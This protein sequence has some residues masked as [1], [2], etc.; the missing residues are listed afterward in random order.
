MRGSSAL[1]RIR[2]GR[3][4]EVAIGGVWKRRIWALLAIGVAVSVIGA[5]VYVLTTEKTPQVI[6]V[7]WNLPNR[8]YQFCQ[9]ASDNTTLY[10]LVSL[11]SPEGLI[12]G[13]AAYYSLQ[14][15]QWSTGR[16]L[17]SVAN[18]TMWGV[19]EPWAP[20]AVF[21][22]G[23]TVVAVFL[24][25]GEWVPGQ[26]GGPEWLGTQFSTFVL[27]WNAS[28]GA[29]LNQT[30]YAIY[31]GWPAEWAVTESDGWIATAAPLVGTSY[32]FSVQT[33]PVP[34]NKT[35]YAEWDQTVHVGTLPSEGCLLPDPQIF[36]SA[37]TVSLWASGGE[38]LTTI[39]S[40]TTGSELWQG[41]VTGW[42]SLESDE[43]GCP[44]ANVVGGPSGLY[45]I[46]N[47][48]F[49]HVDLFNP[50]TRASSPVANL[51]GTSVYGDELSLLPNGELVVT[52]SSHDTYWAFSPAGVRLWIKT[53]N[54]SIVSSPYGFSVWGFNAPPVLLGTGTLFLY[55][56]FSGGSGSGN[57]T[58]DY[59]LPFE[60]V[61][62]TTGTPVWSSSYQGSLCYGPCPSLATVYTPVIGSGQY[63]VFALF[64]KGAGSC[65]VVR[66]P[67]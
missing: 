31:P 36:I 43:Y 54:L 61:N 67:G 55:T 30:H 57:G 32:N 23:G 29:F 48:T 8:C 20:P 12:P 46:Q 27:E 51:S 22:Y 33:V 56:V 41:P 59:N 9:F 13:L 1:S 58:V 6:P 49:P 5:S 66:F 52:D 17:W 60:V 18:F 35:T 21:V 16:L 63:L 26:P 7:A 25:D 62:D 15:Y 34:G 19:A 38:G 40:G 11:N 14:A 44:F 47:G 3:I 65:L 53:L 10:S 4:S 45:Y 28:T 50:L 2:S 42:P 39:L 37:G 64:S 24:A